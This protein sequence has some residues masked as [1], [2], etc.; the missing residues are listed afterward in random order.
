MQVGS[1]AVAWWHGVES[2]ASLRLR[3]LNGM[4]LYPVADRCPVEDDRA[5]LVD[6][7][8]RDSTFQ[9]KDDRVRCNQSSARMT[10]VL[11]T[12]TMILR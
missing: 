2:R 12:R 9:R 1:R 10:G 7:R 6:L 5:K 11:G 3:G 8:A 4:I